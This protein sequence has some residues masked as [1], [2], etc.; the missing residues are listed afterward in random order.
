MKRIEGDL[1]KLALA[2]EFDVVVHG[3]NCFCKMGAGF[4]KQT[5]AAVPEAYQ[6]DLQTAEVDLARYVSLEEAER[7]RALAVSNAEGP[8]LLIS[9]NDSPEFRCYVEGALEHFACGSLALLNPTALRAENATYE[10][11]AAA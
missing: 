5:R 6:A 1:I 2:G 11:A 7:L 10:I 4:A 9:A 3:C 8:T